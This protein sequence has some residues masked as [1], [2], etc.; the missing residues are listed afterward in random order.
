[1]AIETKGATIALPQWLNL[2]RLVDAL[3]HEDWLMAW[4]LDTAQA[5]DAALTSEAPLTLQGGAG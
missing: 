3:F 2:Q 5:G 1:M 4:Q